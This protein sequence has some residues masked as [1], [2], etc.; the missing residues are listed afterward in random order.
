MTANKNPWWKGG[1]T[2][3]WSGYIWILKH[4]HPNTTK[5]GYICEHRYIMSQ[6]LGRPLKDDE[7]VH[8]KNGIKDDNRLENLKLMDNC[9]HV[10]IHNLGKVRSAETKKR[11]SEASKKKWRDGAYKDWTPWNKLDIWQDVK[12]DYITGKCKTHKEIVKK[13]NVSLGAVEFHSKTENWGKARSEANDPH[14]R[15]KRRGDY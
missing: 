14:K 15:S 3:R 9:K 12:N 13:Y 11:M 2:K 7:I 8:H 4:N 1:K 6:Y 5:Q 10:S